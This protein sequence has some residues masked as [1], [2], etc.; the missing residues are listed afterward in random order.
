MIRYFFA[1]WRDIP[2]EFV[3]QTWDFPHIASILAILIL[4]CVGLIAMR[5]ATKK[6][7]RK[8]LMVFAIIE[9]LLEISHII[10]LFQVGETNLYKL[11]PLHLCTLQMF[12]IPL[13]VFSRL[14]SVREF[15]FFSAILGGIFAIVSPVGVAGKYPFFH[16]QTLQTLLLHAFLIF[17][18]LAMLLYDDFY[19][20]LRNFPKVILIALVAIV[21]TAV[22]DIV[23]NEN[24]MFFCAPPEGTFLEPLFLRFGGHCYRIVL[25]ALLISLVFL[26]YLPFEFFRKKGFTKQR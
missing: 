5:F 16:F 6:T 10:W 11:L 8:I 26:L 24:Y 13:A 18:P 9:P 14:P 2:Q 3:F 17:I 22:I 7:A 25:A 15:T 20:R 1:F 19:P 23:S 21:P 12:F 4:L